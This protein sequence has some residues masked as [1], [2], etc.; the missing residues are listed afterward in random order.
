MRSVLL[1]PLLF[2]CSEVRIVVGHETNGCADY[3]PDNPPDEQLVVQEAD[4]SML[5]YRDGVEETCDS[6][7]EPDL[8][9]EDNRVLVREFWTEGVADCSVCFNPTIIIKDPDPGTYE[10]EWYLGDNAVPFDN[11]EFEVD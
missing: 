4:L 7:F 6:L 2:G 10:V 1:I 5:V 8:E 9:L 11:V 3:D